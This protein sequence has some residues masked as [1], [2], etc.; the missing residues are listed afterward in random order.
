M[1]MALASQVNCEGE[2]EADTRHISTH[3]FSTSLQNPPHFT[4]P[5]TVR[6]DLISPYSEAEMK[7]REVKTDLRSNTEPGP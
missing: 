1:P 2:R 7:L 6:K 3:L 5:T 4:D